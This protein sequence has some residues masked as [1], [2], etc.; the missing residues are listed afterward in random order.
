[1]SVLLIGADAELGAALIR[2]LIAQDDEVRVIEVDDR[3]AARWRSLGA[4]VAAGEN[5]DSDLV[6]RAA[7]G[8]RT[9]VLFDGEAAAV[10]P[11]VEGASLAR[12]DRLVLCSS[13]PQNDAMASI[14]ASRIDYVVLRTAVGRRR[15]WGGPNQLSDEIIAEAIDAADDLAG[16][17]KLDL[18]L[19]QPASWQQLGLEPPS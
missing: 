13:D 16:E 1:M 7:Q 12:V 9:L 2:R 11:V 10:Q 19:R 4:H 3:A 17:P 6:E 8:V 14:R 15:F 5:T 18:D